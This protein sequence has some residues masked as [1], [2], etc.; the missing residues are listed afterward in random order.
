MTEQEVLQELQALGT[1]QNRKIY[2]R[3]GVGDNVYGVSFANLGKLQKRIKKD[4]VLAQQLWTT[5]NYEARTL[6]TMIADPGQIDEALLETWV[7]DLSNYA[8]ADAFAGLAA[9]TRFIRPCMERWIESDDEWIARA[10]WHLLAHLA[11]Q[12]DSLPDTFFAP[13]LAQ[14]E[15]TIHTRKNR[16]REAMNNTL[17]AIGVRNDALE[18]QALAVA[19]VIGKVIV[20]HGET[21]CKTPDATAY[22]HKT[23]ARQRQRTTAAG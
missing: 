4:H 16:V 10:G 14:I 21:N 19:A 2:R 1:E 18:A 11:M 15:R 22:I 17:I 13:Y 5:G 7:R 23:R 9:K 12:D 3:H 20:D 6:A 8:I